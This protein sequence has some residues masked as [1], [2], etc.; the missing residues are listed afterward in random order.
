MSQFVDG[1]TKS[2]TASTA[3]AKYLRVALSAGQLIAAGAAVPE[4]GTLEDASFAAGDV[5]AVRLRSAAGT[6]KMVASGAITAGAYCF[7][8]ASGKISASA[9]GTPIGIALEAASA[10]GDVIEVLRETDLMPRAAAVAAAGSAQGDAAALTGMVNVVSA[11]DG[12]KG[13]ILPSAAEG[14]VIHVYS[15]VATNGLKIYP[16][17]SGTINDG[18]ANAAITIEG[19]T[20]AYCIGTSATNWAVIFTANT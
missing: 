2:F 15:S 1:N 5:R 8:A 16:P 20:M 13:V 19:K 14:L 7:G 6:V 9:G 18:S 10:D 12:T 4:I 17:S 11:A 3:I